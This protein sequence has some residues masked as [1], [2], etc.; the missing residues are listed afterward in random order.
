MALRDF[1]ASS[2]EEGASRAN[3]HY[4]P[5][6]TLKPDRRM[7]M[8]SRKMAWRAAAATNRCSSS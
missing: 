4:P 5:R 1:T 7:A 2:L 6:Y 8:P 3:R